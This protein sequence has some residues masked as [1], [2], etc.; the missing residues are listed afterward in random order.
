MAYSYETVVSIAGQEMFQDAFCRYMAGLDLRHMS[1]GGRLMGYTAHEFRRDDQ[2]VSLAISN[3]GQ[4]HFRIVVHSETVEVEPLVL[5]VLTEGVAN[6][7]QP[8]CDALTD[9]SSEQVLNSLIHDLRVAFDR[10][11]GDEG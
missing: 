2:L 7:L 3:E 5:D 8:F 11:L 1:I 4:S 10:I 6:F 9:R